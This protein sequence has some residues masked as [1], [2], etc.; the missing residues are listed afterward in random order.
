M[1]SATLS[2]DSA[3][4]ANLAQKALFFNA[5]AAYISR[6]QAT[7]KRRLAENVTLAT[8]S[9]D[10]ADRAEV[11]LFVHEVFAK[12]YG[13]NVTQCMPELVTLRDEHGALVATFGMR[14]AE[15]SPLFLERYFNIPV[16]T[17]LSKRFNKVITRSQITEIGNL[18]V[19][20]PRNAGVLIAHVIQHSLDIGIEW[21]VATAHHSLQNGLIKGGRDVYALHAADKA[22]L[23][24]DEQAVWG[25]YYDNGPQVVAIRGV[26]QL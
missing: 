10:S 11:E 16:E 13:A 22:C 26:A 21:C 7:S 19:S 2:T 18:A 9:V 4:T 8:S 24:A 14:K 20:N 3:I 6:S 1:L 23:S 5:E 12:T 15:K 25:S 17:L